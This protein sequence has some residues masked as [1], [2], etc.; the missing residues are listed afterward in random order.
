[1]RLL[2]DTARL[3]TLAEQF[4]DL[5][6]LNHQFERA[7]VNV[8]DVARQV[9]SDLAPLAI[10]AGYEPSFETDEEVIEVVGDR[11]AL[12]RAITNL[13]QNAIQHGGRRGIIAVHVSQTTGITVS[14][15]GEGIPPGERERIFE[16]FHRLKN[17]SRGFGLGLNLVQEIIQLHG[18]QVRVLE[19]RAGGAAFRLTFPPTPR[20][21]GG[22]PRS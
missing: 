2:E 8:V 17:R 20:P 22:A 12:E 21:I 16:P 1:M 3:A 10:A 5:Q 6:R 7:L 11:A 14:D 13:V 15:E 4:L 18:G 19:G 9:V